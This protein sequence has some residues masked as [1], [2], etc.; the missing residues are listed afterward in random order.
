MNWPDT[1]GGGG[2]TEEAGGFSAP[3]A[4][5]TGEQ[6]DF[7]LLQLSNISV[8]FSHIDLVHAGPRG[9]IPTCWGGREHLR[10]APVEPVE[11][12]RGSSSKSSLVAPQPG[13]GLG[14]RGRSHVALLTHGAGAVCSGQE[15]SQRPAGSKVKLLPEPSPTLVSF[16]GLKSIF[17]L[18]ADPNS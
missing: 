13:L 11:G 7:Q 17:S 8:H 6:E 9:Q 1:G 10:G 16:K 4:T 15:E 12:L 3:A 18:L 5:P 14:V 2:P